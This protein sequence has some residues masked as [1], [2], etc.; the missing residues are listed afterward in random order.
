MAKLEKQYSGT[1]SRAFW[2]RIAD[3]QDEPEHVML[4]L[5]G[6]ALQDLE[7]RVFQALREAE[8]IDADAEY[9]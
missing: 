9:P 6:C 2:K 1:N 3:I 5:F 4:Y 7:S 8:R